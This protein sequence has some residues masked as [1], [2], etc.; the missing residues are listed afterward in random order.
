MDRHCLN[1]R[2]IAEF[3]A[4]H[5]AVERVLY[6]GLPSH[7]GHEIAKRQMRDF[8]GMLSFVLR[9]SAKAT[10]VMESVRL[11]TR[12]ESLGAV[13]T[14]LEHPAS[15]T[16]ASVPKEEREAHG[17]SNG[18]LR[19]SVGIEDGDDLMADLEQSLG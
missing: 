10:Q 5:A 16:H 18:L 12:A 15:M 6:P 3:L 11:V 4:G 14:L 13:E 7:P 1:A 17:L 19:L 9:D 8:G 2:S